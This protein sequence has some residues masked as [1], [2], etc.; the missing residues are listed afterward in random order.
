MLASRRSSSKR[1]N[2][3][4]RSMKCT[5]RFIRSLRTC[6]LKV[7]K[8]CINCVDVRPYFW[9]MIAFIQLQ[10]LH[11]HTAFPAPCIPRDQLTQTLLRLPLDLFLTSLSADLS[12][13]HLKLLLFEHDLYAELLSLP[14]H[15]NDTTTTTIS[16]FHNQIAAL[17]QKS[18]TIG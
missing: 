12:G 11:I 16:T 8:Y 13:H 14:N 17:I 18:S 2:P 6:C 7:I 10:I 4:N 15:D 1:S 5:I 9:D 3:R